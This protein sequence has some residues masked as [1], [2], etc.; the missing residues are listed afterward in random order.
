MSFFSQLPGRIVIPVR[1]HFPRSAQLLVSFAIALI[2]VTF[3]TLVGGLLK[4]R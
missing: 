3:A 4:G 1:R 2:L